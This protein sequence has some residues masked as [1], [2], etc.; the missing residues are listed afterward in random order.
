MIFDSQKFVDSIKEN[1]NVTVG[2]NSPFT[3]TD[4]LSKLGVEKSDIDAIDY[5]DQTLIIEP[6]S[7]SVSKVIDL[8]A[9][10]GLAYDSGFNSWTDC[11]DKLQKKSNFDKLQDVE[12][13]RN[14]L[15][16]PADGSELPRVIEYQGCYYIDENGR[17]RLTMAKCLGV[18]KAKAVVTVVVKA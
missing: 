6:G 16:N 7:K 8:S 11:L 13:F 3:L 4:K 14:F 1:K 2:F 12:Q 5:S 15:L 9:V 17:H 18:E 10:K